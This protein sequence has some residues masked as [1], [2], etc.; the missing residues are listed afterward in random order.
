MIC[1]FFCGFAL[2]LMK[3]LPVARTPPP[4]LMRIMRYVGKVIFLTRHGLHVQFVHQLM[5]FICEVSFYVLTN[6]PRQTIDWY[7]STDIDADE[8]Y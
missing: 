7:L 1:L 8:D 4:M 6:Y 2:Y 3:V 5:G